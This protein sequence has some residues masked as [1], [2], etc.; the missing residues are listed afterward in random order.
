MSMKKVSLA[1]LFIILVS[2]IAW[3]DWPGVEE[4]LPICIEPWGQ[5][6]PQ[7]VPDNHDGCIIVW[8]D[9]RD[10]DMDVYGQRVNAQGDILWTPH[11]GTQSAH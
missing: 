6:L 9:A 3:A 4:N 5:H 1:I 8:Y 7:I 10:G 2:N 11:G